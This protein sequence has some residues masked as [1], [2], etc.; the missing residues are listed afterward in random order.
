MSNFANKALHFTPLKAPLINKEI[1]TLLQQHILNAFAVKFAFFR[2]TSH[3][4]WVTLA[5]C[6]KLPIR[7]TNVF[8]I[9]CRKL[10][11]LMLHGMPRMWQV[12]ALFHF[13]LPAKAFR[14][15]PLQA[16]SVRGSARCPPVKFA[17]PSSWAKLALHA[18]AICNWIWSEWV[19]W[20]NAWHEL[21]YN[22]ALPCVCACVRMLLATKQRS[23]A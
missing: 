15:A 4:V 9:V 14:R 5:H 1:R 12:P 19:P 21:M 2:L 23:C 6:I 13:N 22:F 8:R 7:T 20:V 3:G 16:F 18:I 10:T 11:F 17:I